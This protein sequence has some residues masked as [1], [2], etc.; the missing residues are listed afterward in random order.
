MDCAG[1]NCEMMVVVIKE[2]IL[3]D[4]SGKIND[5]KME[6]VSASQRHPGTELRASDWAKTPSKTLTAAACRCSPARIPSSRRFLTLPHSSRQAE[7]GWANFLAGG[8]Q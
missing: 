5:F 7:A 6:R 8:P 3:T 4:A 1:C 2:K